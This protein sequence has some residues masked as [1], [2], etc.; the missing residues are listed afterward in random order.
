M[1]RALAIALLLCL[2][3]AAPAA[4]QTRTSTGVEFEAGRL[5]A[6]LGEWEDGARPADDLEAP[7]GPGG[8]RF[9]A[10]PAPVTTFPAPPA[11]SVR[12]TV[13]E[14]LLEQGELQRGRGKILLYGGI[15]TGVLGTILGIAGYARAVSS[16]GTSTSNGLLVLSGLGLGGLGGAGIIVGSIM[17]H[18]G[19]KKMDRA[20]RTTSVSAISPALMPGGGAGLV[21][22]GE[23]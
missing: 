19:G 6:E 15:G 13:D 1:I 11:P 20:R 3:I 9:D 12:T 14:A 22:A 17:L 5:D 4:A 2:A 18:R 8:A 16:N 7:A 21:V 10:P 23:F